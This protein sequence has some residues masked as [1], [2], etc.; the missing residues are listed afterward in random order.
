[1]EAIPPCSPLVS[2]C[3]EGSF[4]RKRESSFNH[5]SKDDADVVDEKAGISEGSSLRRSALPSESTEAQ[6]IATLSNGDLSAML[7]A[8]S[9]VVYLYAAREDEPTKDVRRAIV[10]RNQI[11]LCRVRSLGRPA[12]VSSAF[13]AGLLRFVRRG[14]PS[15]GRQ[16]R[17]DRR[18]QRENHPGLHVRHSRKP[19]IG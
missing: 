4:N 5:R 1:M 10:A 15:A 16:R 7:T 3:R 12:C 14:H 8:V 11:L 17:L 18:T 19:A 9:H 13:G 6:Q 2:N